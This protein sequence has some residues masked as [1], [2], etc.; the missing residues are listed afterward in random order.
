MPSNRERQVNLQMMNNNSNSSTNS[1]ENSFDNHG[2]RVEQ[3]SD[4]SF[5]KRF[6]GTTGVEVVKKR[7]I[8]L[9]KNREAAR[10]CRRKKKE[11]IKC[12]EKRVIVLDQQNKMLIEELKSLKELYCNID[13]T[14]KH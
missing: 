11:Y 10:E 7:E 3:Q 6:V 8:R 2:G 5:S 1:S 9:L 14:Q 12:L 13:G 4:N